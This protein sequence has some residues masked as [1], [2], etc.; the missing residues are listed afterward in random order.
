MM[1]KF[2]FITVRSGS[3]RLENK[4]LLKINKKFTIEYLIENIK[5]S[6]YSSNII[7]CTTTKDEDDL[8][9][10]L[11]EKHGIH[12]F[13]GSSKDKINRWF[14]CSI[15]YDVDFFVNVDGDDLFFDYELGDKILDEYAN[16]DFVDGHGYYI[17][18][19]GISK[20]G[21]NKVNASKKTD[22]TE[23]IRT[24][25]NNQ[26]NIS[27]IKLTD[28]DKKYTKSDVRMTL[29]YKEDLLFFKEVIAN[30]KD[31]RFD[32]IIEFLN[33]NP[34]IKNINFHLD[35]AWKKNQLGYLK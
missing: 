23:Y 26:N 21:I 3:S 14:E 15:K 7:L 9:A 13:R 33:D 20:D 1:N 30:V 6:K 5:K 18:I 35:E 34:E 22:D 25:F 27:K 11:A 19:Y 4:A 31:L 24:F 12:L 16:Y 28:I 17:D 2:Y 32:N 8:I 10:T 29:D